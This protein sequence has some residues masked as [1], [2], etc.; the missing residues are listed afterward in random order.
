MLAAI[1]A[2]AVVLDS[3][4]SPDPA[5]LVNQLGSSHYA[6]RVSAEGELARLGRTALPALRAAKHSKDAEIRTRS[7]ALVSRIETSMLLESTPVGLDFRDTPLTEAIERVGRQSGLGLSLADEERP[8]LAGRR[9]TLRSDRPLPFWEA[10]DALCSAGNLH[11]VQGDPPSKGVLDGSLLL[12]DGPMTGP[13]PVSDSGAFRVQLSSIH[14]QSE[15]QLNQ[16][17]PGL[18]TP[19][20][21]LVNGV[22]V[23]RQSPGTNREFYLQLVLSAEPRLSITRNG[24]IQVTAAVDDRGDSLL[25]PG[26][27]S[28]FQLLREF[29][30]LFLE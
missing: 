18:R 12:L 3:H 11:P 24:P 15:I 8:M 10:V 28:G 22:D 17:R 6:S 7:V 30:G 20:S 2:M 14:Y 21:Q 26:G 13:G 1:M 23:T 9:I 5:S 25:S 27:S 29:S 4:S 19:G 16:A